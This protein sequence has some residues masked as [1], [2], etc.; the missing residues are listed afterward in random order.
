[1]AVNLYLLVPRERGD[2]IAITTSAWVAH[3][4]IDR[5]SFDCDVVGT[6]MPYLRWAFTT[7]KSQNRW[8]ERKTGYPVAPGNPWLELL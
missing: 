7:E 5:W 2:A 1:M 8:L 6:T 4:W 3:A